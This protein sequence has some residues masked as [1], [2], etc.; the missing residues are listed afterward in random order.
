LPVR[1]V[2]TPF[3][4]PSPKLSICLLFFL[5]LFLFPASFQERVQSNQQ[6]LES[7]LGPFPPPPVSVYVL[8][9]PPVVPLFPLFSERHHEERIRVVLF[10]SLPSRS[11]VTV[12]SSSYQLHPRYENGRHRLFFPLFFFGTKSRFSVLKSASVENLSRSEQSFFFP[13]LPL[14]HT[15]PSLTVKF[16]VSNLLPPPS[17]FSPP[18]N[19]N[20]PTHSD[21]F[22]KRRIYE[23]SFVV[24]FFPFSLPHL[25]F[26]LKHLWPPFPFPSVL[27]SFPV[28]KERDTIE[29]ILRGRIETEPLFPF[30]RPFPPCCS[31][32]TLYFF[33]S[34]I[35]ARSR[36]CVKNKNKAPSFSPSST[37]GKGRLF[38]T[39]FFLYRR[40]EEWTRMMSPFLFFFPSLAFLLIRDR[41][42]NA[43]FFSSTAGAESSCLSSFF[44]DLAGWPRW[45]AISTRMI[46]FP[47]LPF[48]FLFVVTGI[49]A[50]FFS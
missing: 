32:K 13:P 14:P 35:L 40:S 3:L 48:F 37:S 8:D 26:F 4:F 46:S 34:L 30:S 5:H 17:F 19:A 24:A 27:F 41:G 10:P 50:S 36:I 31:C 22:M 45:E 21:F 2:F 23:L 47:S 33:F 15:P 1:T 25:S 42:E 28:Y 18:L 9:A 16:N 44:Q 43:P 11:G 7:T 20:G 38:P 49:D 6:E 12:Y 29:E 39:F